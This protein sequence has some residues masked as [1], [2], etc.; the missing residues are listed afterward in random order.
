MPFYVDTYIE[1]FCECSAGAVLLFNH[2]FTSQLSLVQNIFHTWDHLA[3]LQKDRNPGTTG[4]KESLSP[5]GRFG[6][7]DLLRHQSY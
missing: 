4:P 5:K 7:K 6:L 3:G 1:P 2:G